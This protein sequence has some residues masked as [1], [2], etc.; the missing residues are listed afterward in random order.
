MVDDVTRP[1]PTVLA[2]GAWLKNQACLL[3]SER[4]LWSGPHGDLSTPEA[5]QA[6]TQSVD[7]L[8]LPD[9]PLAAVAH[10]LHPDFFSTTL[11]QRCASQHGVPAIAVQHHH[12]HVAAVVAEHRLEQPVIGLALDGVGLG[13]DGTPWG[14]E[15]LWVHHEKWQRL[16]HFQP[17]PL[18]GGDRAATEPWRMGCA[19]LHALG[20]AEYMSTLF[21][22]AVGS[23][24]VDAVRQLLARDVRC[25]RGSSAGRWF[26]A[27]S[28]LLGLVLV[29][30]DEAQAPMALERAAAAWLADHGNTDAACDAL[31]D[32]NMTRLMLREDGLLDP[33]PLLSTLLS[34]KPP[35]RRDAGDVGRRAALFHLTLA[36]ALV[37]W[38]TRAARMCDVGTVC[39]GGGC[40]FN[41]ILSAEVEHG[42]RAHGL[43]VRRPVTHSCGDAGLALGQAWVAA[44]QTRLAT[45]PN[46]SKETSCASP[47]PLK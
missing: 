33:L 38:A 6:L 16:G 30:H 26:D 19:V 10:D 31:V 17:L 39:L 9:R 24:R 21:A 12:A 40:F 13:T 18:P 11:A 43:D 41:R 3:A 42:L 15:L 14:G 4:V 7:A 36:R 37:D 27:A 32:P 34:A 23:A 2:T 46:D 22:H 25:P 47:F 28:A 44:H 45:A 29:Q 20:Q 8:F 35:A 5:C 1:L